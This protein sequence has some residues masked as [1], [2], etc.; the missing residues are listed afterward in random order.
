[1][2]ID[3]P[4]HSNEAN[5]SR[6]LSAGLACAGR[7]MAAQLRD[8]RPVEPGAGPAGESVRG[9]GARGKGQYRRRGGTGAPAERAAAARIRS[10]QGRP[11]GRS[12]RGRRA[13]AR[14]GGLARLPRGGGAAVPPAPSGPSMCDR[15]WSWRGPPAA[16]PLRKSGLRPQSDRQRASRASRWS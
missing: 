3:A 6:V 5:F 4:V 8:V 15:R 1:M 14:A 2:A 9:Q 10:F 16:P 11:G 12:R 7:P 13:R